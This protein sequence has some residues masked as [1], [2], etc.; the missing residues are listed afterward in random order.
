VLPPTLLTEEE[1]NSLMQIYR[2][3]TGVFCSGIGIFP[4]FGIGVENFIVDK[5]QLV[6][7]RFGRRFLYFLKDNA[8]V[9]S[10]TFAGMNIFLTFDYEL[11]FGSSSGSVEKCMI[12]PTQELLELSKKFVVPMTFFVDVGYLIRM[13][14]EGQK[15]SKLK[16][17]L[18]KVKNQIA[19]MMSCGCDVQLHIHPHWERSYYNGQ[20][21]VFQTDGAYKLADFDDQEIA[22]IV[23]FYKTYLEELCGK[24]VHTFRAGGW[25]IQPF[26]KLYS[27]FKE[28]GIHYDSSVFSGGY[29]ESSNYF[30]DFRNAPRKAFYR[31]E[32][33]VCVEDEN[34]SFTEYPISSLKYSPLFYWRL[35]VL[36]RLFPRQHKMVGDGVFLKQPGRKKSVLCNF[37]W[38]HVSTD[39][40]YASKLQRA[41]QESERN[42]DSEIVIIGHPKGNTK[43]SI[44]TLAQFI[45]KNYQRHVFRSFQEL[46]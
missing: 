9:F 40:Y 37:T 4:I 23:S 41:L 33:E 12:E 3:I 38:N 36:G 15:H 46:K 35:Y 16:V 8:P 25:C 26:S 11:F 31:F 6:P 2:L 5:V 24:Q 17:D 29:Y 32:R 44:R 1:A 27:I 39:G 42:K 20:K 30:F 18:V 43:F 45:D 21:W 28:L 14:T 34:G 13:E 7:N 19:E 10:Y 22:H